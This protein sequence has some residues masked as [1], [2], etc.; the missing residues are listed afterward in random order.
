M[1]EDFWS[2]NLIIRKDVLTK[3]DNIIIGFS[4]GNKMSY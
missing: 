1:D 4:K 2:E 3:N